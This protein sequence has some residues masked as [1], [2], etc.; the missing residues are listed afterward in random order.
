VIN[1]FFE[2]A[3]T[4]PWY[5]FPVGGYTLVNTGDPQYGSKTPRVDRTAALFASVRQVPVFDAG[6]YTARFS[7]KVE[8]PDPNKCYVSLTGVAEQSFGTATDGNWN[9]YTKTFTSTA[10]NRQFYR[11]VVSCEQSPQTGFVYFDN[12]ELLQGTL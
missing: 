1:P 2:D 12:L 9:T 6:T 7:V 11:V 8:G 5:L 4:S 10:P 3:T